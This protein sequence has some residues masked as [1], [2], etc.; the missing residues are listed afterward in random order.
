MKAVIGI[1]AGP[2]KQNSEDCAFCGPNLYDSGIF[3]DETGEPVVVGVADGVGGNAGGRYASRFIASEFNKIK[4]E[5][6]DMPMLQETMKEL[7]QKLI[8]FA[9]KLRGREAMA[10]TL[11]AVVKGRDGY[12]LIQSGNTRLYVFQGS[13]LKQLSD[14]QTTYQ[15]LIQ[16]GQYETADSCNR[17]EI[18]GCFGGG[19]PEYGNRITVHHVFENGLPSSFLLTSDGIHD[20]VDID[21]MESI[22]NSLESDDIIIQSLFD[23]ALKNGS[24]DDK[25]VMIIKE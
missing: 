24:I 10:T 22:V 4:F 8:N 11:T 23:K 9:A 1:M 21:D 20:Y 16:H 15:W 18:M 17:S 2:N 13:Y 3:Q 6:M 12:Y 19:S 7:N 5:D 14:D 25:T